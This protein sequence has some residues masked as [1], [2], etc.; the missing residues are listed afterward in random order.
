[1][2]QAVEPNN[3]IVAAKGNVSVSVHYAAMCYV[4]I[5][6]RP[7]GLCSCLVLVVLVLGVNDECVVY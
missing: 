4:K 3:D 1:M 6:H 2:A 7:I 5:M